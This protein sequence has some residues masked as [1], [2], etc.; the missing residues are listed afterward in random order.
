MA[1]RLA[2]QRNFVTIT[3]T[4][5]QSNQ[6]PSQMVEMITTSPSNSG[7]ISGTDNI[8]TITPTGN[9]TNNESP[10]NNHNGSVAAAATTVQI[11]HNVH[12]VFV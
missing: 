9:T 2:P 11:P 3:P 10:L 1:A 12:Q 4:T 5:N 6:V 8:I 7:V